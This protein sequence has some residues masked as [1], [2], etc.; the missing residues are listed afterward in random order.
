M[1]TIAASHIHGEVE[2]VTAND[3]FNDIFGDFEVFSD[4]HSESD[5]SDI[6]NLDNIQDSMVFDWS[7]EAYMNNLNNNAK[8]EPQ[9]LY[10]MEVPKPAS[11]SSPFDTNNFPTSVNDISN[12]IEIDP[13]FNNIESIYM[14]DCNS[15]DI[16]YDISVPIIKIEEHVDAN[17]DEPNDDE[18]EDGDEETVDKNLLQGF[19]IEKREGRK[20]RKYSSTDESDEEWAPEPPK[21]FRRKTDSKRISKTPS[22]R[23][24]PQRR[25]PGT[26]LKIT[27]WIVELLRNPKYN[28]KVITWTEERQGMFMIKDTVAY[29]KLWGKVKGND[30]MTYEKL[31]RAMRY[32]YKNDELR[33]VPEQ[34]LT[35]QFGANMVNFRA[36]NPEDPNFGLIHKR[37]A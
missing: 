17:D 4:S 20:Q 6:G 37:I 13:D 7:N 35:Y 2:G 22:R 23:P 14:S 16:S 1:D 9:S 30:N 11:P 12:L 24:V 31:S 25:S 21:Y 10:S 5:W 33:M 36:E 32:S 28:P 29:A 26:K 27:Q 15:L 34:R 3:S 19:E 18:K 8:V